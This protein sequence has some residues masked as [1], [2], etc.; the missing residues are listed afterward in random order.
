[1]LFTS[2]EVRAVKCSSLEDCY[3]RDSDDD[4]GCVVFCYP[5]G[6]GST[7]HAHLIEGN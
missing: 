2:L 6:N 1:M 3:D 5:K 4:T 7:G